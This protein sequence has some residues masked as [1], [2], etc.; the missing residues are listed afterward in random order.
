MVAI[1]A[2]VLALLGAPV[3]SGSDPA[4]TQAAI[5]GIVREYAARNDLAAV[6]C[7]VWEGDQVV[8]RFAVGNSMAGVPATPEMKFRVGGVTL[9]C[10]STALLRFV[11][12]NRVSLDDRLSKWYPSI[13]RAD[14][15]TLRML[16]NC[17]AGIP[18]YV[19]VAAF[20]EVAVNQPFREWTSDELIAV[21]LSVPLPY[22]PGKGWNYSHTNFVI[23][24]EILQKVAG[25]PM[26]D[27]L[28]EE[29]WTP[30]GLRNTSYP[31]TPEIPAPVLHSYSSDRGVY[32]NSTFWNPSWTSSS[33]RMISDLDD[34]GTIGRELGSGR[35]LSPAMRRERTAPTTVGLGVNTPQAYYGTGVIV[36]NGWIAQNP[37]FGGYNLILSHLPSRNLTIVLSSTVGPTSADIA[38][39]TQIW[40]ELVKHLAPEAPIPDFVK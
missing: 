35:L 24:G 33:G 12:Q 32:E 40:K 25:K 14:Q 34:L 21:A 26:A 20:N 3:S 9:T 39:S 31:L 28:R 13:P 37:R 23:L 17:T 19:P 4:A 16:A 22:E 29:I 10:V 2:A 5:Q 1:S 8:A 11:D 6:I 30:L 38:H 27:I 18:D 36:L 15:I 7:G